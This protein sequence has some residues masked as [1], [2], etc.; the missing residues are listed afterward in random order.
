VVNETPRPLYRQVRDLLLIVQGT[1]WAPGPVWTGAEN[2]ACTG[3]RSP[4]RPARRESLYRLSY[5]GTQVHLILFFKIFS[6]FQ[7]L[8]RLKDKSRRIFDKIVFTKY[9]S[10]IFEFFGGAR[11]WWVS[12]LQP[13]LGC[14]QAG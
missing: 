14:A 11:G 3:I 5:P 9:V 8:S 4:N 12:A 10:F 13:S 6:R 1:V 7:W 2:V